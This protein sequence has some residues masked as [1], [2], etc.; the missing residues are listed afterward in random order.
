[1]KCAFLMNDVD[2]E[3]A[4][5]EEESSDEERDNEDDFQ[6]WTPQPLKFEGWLGCACHQ[7]QLVVCDGYQELM[8]YRR[9]QAAFSKAKSIC[10][11]SR[12]SSHFCYAL[13]AKIPVPNET[14]WFS[15]LR[16]HEHILKHFHNINDALGVVNRLEL[17]LSSTDKENLTQVVQVM[18]YLAEA[19]DL[20]QASN[21][22]T[23]GRVILVIDSLENAL[24]T[25]ERS[26]PAINALCERLPLT[27]LIQ[28]STKLLQ[29][30]IHR[31][32]LH[33]QTILL[34][35]STSYF[36]LQQ[37]KRK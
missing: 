21:Q 8:H 4:D 36:C 10:S 34:P 28:V 19:T 7:L 13:T 37:S 17:V 23:S 31:L 29:R 15:Y 26:T 2:D 1:M 3:T 11:L 20:L 5:R 16:L 24:K 9:V 22:P 12:K 6:Y 35:Q 27:F 33:L 25:T 30:L 18:Q 14:R 32:S